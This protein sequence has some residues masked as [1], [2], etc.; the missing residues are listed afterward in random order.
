MHQG[1]LALN[2]KEENR[3][4]WILAAMG[5]GGGL[6]VL[7]E[8]VVGVALPTL[9]QDLGMSHVAAHW[10]VSAY[11]LAITGFAAAAGKLGDHFGLKRV[12]VASLL[13]FGATS[14]AAGFAQ[15]GAW[16]ITARVF[17]GIGA[18]VIYPVS[19]AMVVKVFPKEQRGMAM[20]TC[21][22]VGTA[23]LAAGPLVGGLFTDLISW[24]WIFWINVPIVAAIL[25]VLQMA[26]VEP[27]HD[28]APGPGLDWPGLVTLVVGL[29]LVVFAIMQGSSW[30]WGNVIILALLAS[31]IAILALFVLLER[32]RL[33][34]LI[35]IG[36]FASAGFSACNLALFVA[37]FSKIA[38]VIFLA[39][40]LQ[41]VLGMSALEAGLC[42]LVAVIGTPIM[43]GPT[44]RMADKL[45]A[46]RLEL[47]G[48]ALATLGILWIALAA[49]WNS[50]AL[51]IPGLLVW[52]FAL[53]V[54]FIPVL[55]YAMNAVPPDQHGQV[56]GITMTARLLGGTIGMA[57]CST[58]HS[59]T[60]SFQAV[61]LMSG[62]L[63]AAALPVVWIFLKQEEAP[64]ASA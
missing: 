44:G 7:D 23:F 47:A 63:L 43:A 56:S 52:G 42:L 31:G 34:P 20:G 3:K 8:T 61:F 21:I 60:G 51:L 32:K 37:Q 13:L 35:A 19:L 29:T 30:G 4:W 12:M 27:T 11:F 41:D 24:R 5:A 48:L 26:W 2:I 59:M 62:L 54:C 25:L 38:V 10:V 6:I 55:R 46:R 15:S 18:A 16:L 14:L 17:E 50:Y 49:G 9:R 39:L 28:K 40:Y 1:G 57:L 33:D 45:G 64:S 22:S 58:L 53:S 36:L